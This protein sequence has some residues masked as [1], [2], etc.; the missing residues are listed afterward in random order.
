MTALSVGLALALIGNLAT[1]TVQV[2]GRWWPWLVWTATGLL[3]LTAVIVEYLQRRADRAVAAAAVDLD[4]VVGVLAQ[5]VRR[6]WLEEAVFRRVRQPLPLWVRWSSTGRPVAA[7]RD[8]V[9][10]D[11][12][13]TD[14]REVPLE[15]D[16]N[17]IVAA[18]TSLPHAQLVILGEAGAGKTVM[19]MQLT[20]GLIEQQVPGDPVP[21]LLP[22]ASWN[23]NVEHAEEF[24]TRRLR[25]EY[26]FLAESGT[27]GDLAGT[28]LASGRLLP[29]LDGLDEI[30]D[31]RHGAAVDALDRF[32]A[33]GRPLV[34]TCR[35]HEYEQAVTRSGTVVSRAA[36][37]EIEP[38]DVDRVIAF[39]SHPAPSRSR[40]KP[41]FDHLRAHP[42][43]VLARALSTPLMVA[44][45]RTGFQDPATDPAT[46]LSLPDR[47][48]VTGALLDGFVNSAYQPGPP[49]GS[50]RS[51]DPAKAT[52]WLTCLA[53]HLDRAGTRDLWWWQLGPG[54]MSRRPARTEVTVTVLA[55]LAAGLAAGLGAALLV[56][57]GFALGAAVLGEAVVGISAT[58]ALRW[59]W[60]G[61]Y[62]PYEPLALPRRS[63]RGYRCLLFGGG[64][65]LLPSPSW[66][67]LAGGLLYGLAVQFIPAWS[68]PARP[69]RATPRLT[70]HA[71]RR[72]ALAAA[73]QHAVIAATIFAAVAALVPGAPGPL[74]AATTAALVYGAAAAF[75]A[76]LWTW[77]RY[78]LAHLRLAARGHLPWRLWVFL[79]DAHHRG[80]LR[81]AGTAWQFRHALLQD[82]LGAR[83]RG[84]RVGT[85]DQTAARKLADLLVEHGRLEELRIRADAGDQVAGRRLADLFLDQGHLDEALSILRTQAD[86]AAENPA[87]VQERWNAARHLDDVLVQ[88]GRFEEL[89]ARAD[90][91]DQSAGRRLDSLDLG[92]D[93]D[94]TATHRHSGTGGS[95]TSR[96]RAAQMNMAPIADLF[97][98]RGDLDEAVELLRDFADPGD[99][100]A[101]DRLYDLLAEQGRLAETIASWRTGTQSGPEAVRLPR[102]LARDGRLDEAVQILRA[103]ADA[104]DWNAALRLPRLLADYGRVDEAIAL[105]R[106]RADAGD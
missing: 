64:F 63:R 30:A 59:L 104:G 37:V 84:T 16:L 87:A 28:L 100:L 53:A 5:E 55:V 3:A 66:A 85:G 12:G 13:G 83:V 1:N 26:G 97:A 56:G 54:L 34:V 79:D 11:A 98:E 102:F 27:D 24:I 91:G 86:V 36:V 7:G 33:A 35:S 14:W 80:T 77:T 21:V 106:A 51:Y 6:Q 50:L 78:R 96:T 25:E 67:G 41:V 70:L 81:Q 43:G 18:F 94:I 101:T 39:L 38:T 9:L 76:G 15:G 45:A 92:P 74:L 65:G 75:G 90:A 44:L 69:R 82:H 49:T 95:S 99:D 31:G 89:R 23:P 10:D 2:A 47:R 17:G 40:W 88:H 19:A 58:G 61:G 42:D 62:P 52:R 68:L 93:G 103:R 48:T 46:L 22:I 4:E 72:N 20:L 105:L 8:A 60:P 29:V 32:A 57:P 73:L 71:N